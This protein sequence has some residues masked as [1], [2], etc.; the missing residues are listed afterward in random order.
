MK[1]QLTPSP[2]TPNRPRLHPKRLPAFT[3]LELMVVIGIIS[4][5][6]VAL[7]PAVNSLTKSSGRKAA[8]GSL[9]GAVEQARAQAIKDGRATYLV[10]VG[11]LAGVSDQS[12]IGRYGYRSYAIFQ[13]D[14]SNP[15]DH[16]SPADPADSAKPKVQLTPW[17]ILPTGISLRSDMEAAASI[18]KQSSFS[19][20]PG[21][22]GMVQDFPYLMFNES[23]EVQS[24]IPP[25]GPVPLSIFEGSV[26]GTTELPTSKTII[27]ETVQV[28]RLTGRAVSTP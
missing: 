1:L 20:T 25:A 24:P 12:I 22:S 2:V 18:W 27:T 19:F 9:L 11:Q 5:M 4:I 3:L 28:S 7:V 10:L 16:S 8:I 21:A 13:D 15:G 14:P 17:K 6:L 23:G 26:D